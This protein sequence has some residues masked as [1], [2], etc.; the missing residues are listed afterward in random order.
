VAL[1]KWAVLQ[2]PWV[3]VVAVVAMQAVVAVV[4]VERVV[5]V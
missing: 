5:P 2:P 3:E 1:H 4:L